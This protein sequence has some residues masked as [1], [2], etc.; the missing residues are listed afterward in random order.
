MKSPV[1]ATC[2]AA[3][4]TSLVYGIGVASAWV[5]PTKA[6][7]RKGF[8][9]TAGIV[10]A[11]TFAPLVSNSAEIFP[12]LYDDPKH[13]NCRRIV[14]VKPDG[15]AAVSGTDGNPGCPEDGSGDVWRVV[16][17]VEGNT[18]LVDFSAKGGPANIKGVWEDKSPAGI[19]WPDGNKW[20][21]KQ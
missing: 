19:R 13:P 21:V 2:L 5:P 18:I 14:V 15:S 9:T 8:F 4:A 12:R 17:E 1:F 7:T 6:M 3:M 10:G 20:T 16:G 11:A